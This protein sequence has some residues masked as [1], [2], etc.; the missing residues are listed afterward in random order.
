MAVRL[1]VR[2]RLFFAALAVMLGLGGPSG[3]YLEGQMRSWLEA[4]VERELS[5]HA[6]VTAEAVETGRWQLDTLAGRLG[7]STES[8]ITIIADDGR[9]LGDSEVE[10][11]RLPSLDDHSQRPE[12]L[13]AKAK[14]LGTSRRES[15]TLDQRM[16]YVA[17]P[18]TIAGHPGVVRAAVPL[19][20][21]D[22]VIFKLRLML[23]AAA[24]IGL[25]LA[26]IMAFWASALVSRPVK[27]LVDRSRPLVHVEPPSQARP[28]TTDDADLLPGS[29]AMMAHELEGTLAAL[30]RERDRFETV[31]ESMSE[32][33]LALDD[34]RRIVVANPAAESLL[35]IATTEPRP[36]LESCVDAPELVELAGRATKSAATTEMAYG[37]RRLLARA[38]PL[39]S[40]RGTV[41]V[42][43][44]VTE[45][46]R[47]ETIRKD[48]V[49]NVSHELRT[50]VSIIRANAETLLAG[51]LE[52][53]KRSRSFVDAI[54]RH[55]ER[56][57]NLIADLL[58]LSRIEAGRY[59]LDFR[60]LDCAT[61]ARRGVEAVEA[62]A[63]GRKID[64]RLPS[65]AG[66]EVRA[67]PKAADQILMNLLDNALKYSSGDTPVRVDVV[68]L[69]AEVRF[70][71]VDSGQGIAPEQRARIF[72]R[73]YRV[74]PGRSRD[75]GGTGL[76]LAIVKHL[77]ESM[78]G[79]VGVE[80]AEPTGS[81]FWFTLPRVR[82]IEVEDE[83]EAEAEVA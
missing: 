59:K 29:V 66:L 5:H 45:M 21:V 69:E 72:E 54:H 38:T 57:S 55:A 31:L 81:K 46:R 49:A 8:R 14:G 42:M 60:N 1:G 18:A 70:E 34:E 51:G 10:A 77:A 53:P 33:V 32:A 47:L 17:V 74:D 25:L 37:E 39:A 2:G 20:E 35:K 26:L 56:L 83:A 64:I 79:H 16:V 43:H 6:K 67:D 28:L 63:G 7:S 30:A 27:Q 58:D 11:A 78:G 4:R 82:E 19:A 9:V 15:A 36:P 22:A 62:K 41:I 71:V 68:A 3:L 65:E 12:V 73:F 61:V 80:A 76:G 50:P 52:D 13:E 44:D 40:A 24:A 23:G 48:F 75:R